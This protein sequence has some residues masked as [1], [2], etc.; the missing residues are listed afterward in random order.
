MTYTLPLLPY[1]YDALAH[2]KYESRRG[3]YLDAWWNVVDWGRVAEGYEAAT[4]GWDGG[5]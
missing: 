3:D 1:P 5:S 2:L 4:G